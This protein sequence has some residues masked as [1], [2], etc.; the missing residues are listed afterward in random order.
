MKTSEK[1]DLDIS[2]P[3]SWPCDSS[4]CL[5]L[6]IRVLGLEAQVLLNITAI[7]T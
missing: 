5:D 3:W 2:S 7:N 6:G 1:F 4:P